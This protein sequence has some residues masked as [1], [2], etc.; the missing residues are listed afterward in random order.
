MTAPIIPEDLVYPVR[1]E[2]RVTFASKANTFNQRLVDEVVV[3][4][5]SLG[6]WMNTTATQVS[7]DATTASNAATNA[8]ASAS[9]ASTDA[10]SAAVSAA[11]AQAAAGL[12]AL[13]GNAD[14]ALKVNAT[15]DGVEFANLPLTSTSYDN[16]SSGLTSTDGNSAVDEVY[17]KIRELSGKVI[18]SG[19]ATFTNA[20]NNIF[21]PNVGVGREVGDVIQIVGST[22]NDTEFTIDSITD[23]DNVIV[24]AEHAGGTTSKSLVDETATVTVT[25]LCK[26]YLADSGLGRDYVDVAASRLAGADYTENPNRDTEVLIICTVSVAADLIIRVDGVN[27][28]IKNTP[29]GVNQTLSAKIPKGAVYRLVSSAGVITIVRWSILG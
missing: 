17:T 3:Q 29:A 4:Q 6:T 19:S 8:S 10:T 21:L 16:T 23:A 9:S 2:D 20:T 15:E 5:N 22:N 25:L 27:R 1:G 12:P 26:W 13:T 24:N 18:A 14:K 7:T 11:A 28:V